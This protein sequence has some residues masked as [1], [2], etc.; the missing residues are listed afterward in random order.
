MRTRK[1][2]SGYL[3]ALFVLLSAANVMPLMA[4]QRFTNN[5]FLAGEKLDYELY[6]QWGILWKSIG[7][8]QFNTQNA[9]YNGQDAYK[10]SLLASTDKGLD[11]VFKMRD[12]LSTY[13]SK[14]LVPLYFKK[15]AEEGKRY[16]VDEVTYSYRGGLNYVD[17]VRS[18]RGSEVLKTHLSD[19]RSIYDMVSLIVRAR[20]DDFSLTKKGDQYQLPLASGK[21]LDEVTLI[22]DGLRNVKGKDGVTYRCRTYHVRILSEKDAKS[23]E[24]MTFYV[25]DDRNF[26]PVCIDLALNFG[27]AKAYL[28]TYQG[29]RYPIDCVVR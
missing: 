9:S 23:K 5:A 21:R 24:V 6:F 7:K 22:Y 12:T 2:I 19:T 1:Y 26:L 25:T 13:V 27:S 18:K 20:N 3:L 14:D 10:V 29:L 11:G 16:C 15:A 17:Q 28:K 4:Q 8:A